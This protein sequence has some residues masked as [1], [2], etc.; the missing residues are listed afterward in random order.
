[1]TPVAAIWTLV[2]VAFVLHSAY[3]ILHDGDDEDGWF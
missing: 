2:A 3:T 1:M